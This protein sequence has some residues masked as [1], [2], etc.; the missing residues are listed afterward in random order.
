QPTIL[1]GVAYWGDWTGNEH[2]TNVTTNVD[3]W[4]TNLGATTPPAANG[5][6]P[7]EA[8]VVGTATLAR[9]GSTTVVYVPG[10]DGAFYALNASTGAVI[11]RT[12]LG[13]PPDWFIWSSPAITSDSLYIG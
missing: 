7:T 1:N 4:A 11:W 13:A 8:G 12:S 6:L 5:C 3:L 10:G 2:A 9:V